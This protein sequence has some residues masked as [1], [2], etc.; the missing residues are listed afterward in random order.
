MDQIRWFIQFQLKLTNNFA[1]K[2]KDQIDLLWNNWHTER[3]VVRKNRTKNAH[4]I[5]VAE[6][7]VL[8]TI[9]RYWMAKINIRSAEVS[10][11]SSIDRSL[12]CWVLF[13]SFSFSFRSFS[14]DSLQVLCCPLCTP[15]IGARSAKWFDGWVA[16]SNVD[17]QQEQRFSSALNRRF[18]TLSSLF[19]WYSIV[20]LN[21][22][23]ASELWRY[24][25]AIWSVFVCVRR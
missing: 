13:L 1:N 11:L 2:L 10:A 25:T 9:S 19:G 4:G 24:S 6:M 8:R 5:T 18:L 20:L 23:V 16:V 14:F 7:R 22:L 21:L 3:A 17:T 12:V 15:F